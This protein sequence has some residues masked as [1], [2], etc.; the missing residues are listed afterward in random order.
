LA[1]LSLRS[2]LSPEDARDFSKY[3]RLIM[4]DVFHII[5]S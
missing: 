2:S 5:I 3:S 1:L 4:I